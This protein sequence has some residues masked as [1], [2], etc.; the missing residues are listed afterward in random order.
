MSRRG[1]VVLGAAFAVLHVGLYALGRWP[2]QRRLWGDESMYWEA[3]G[4]ALESG[5]SGLEPLWPPLYAWFLAGCRAL[6][7]ARWPVELAQTLLLLA[8][9]LLLRDLG[10]RLELPAGAADLAA[11]IFLLYPTLAAFGHF[12]WPEVLHLLWLVAAA[13]ILAARR[14]RLG[15]CAALG[16]VLGLALLTKSLLG[17]FLP[18]LLAPLL[19]APDGS[20]AAAAG[21]GPAAT[22]PP[23]AVARHARL[24]RLG[25]VLLALTA[26]VAPTM[27]LNWRWHGRPMIANSARFNAWVGL[28]DRA[29]GQLADEIVAEEYIAWRRSAPDFAGREAILAAKIRA[30][31]S[32]RGWAELLRAQLGR[33]YFRLL[34]RESFFTDQLPGGAVHD[35]GGGYRRPPRRVAA[36]ARAAHYASYAALLLAAPFGLAAAWRQ[37]RRWSWLAGA[38]LAYHGAVFLVLHVKTRY[39]LQLLPLVA[40]LGASAA[41]AWGRW[42]VGRA[43]GEALH[44]PLGQGGVAGAAAGGGLLLWLAFGGP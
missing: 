25:V 6:A 22:F 19:I 39:R 1:W 35:V 44:A 16:V 9:A 29:G 24:A 8:S 4:R 17:P 23:A 28:N 7:D 13:W 14:D 3:G 32:E 30:L 41:L 36:L 34:D 11:A 26:T 42:A 38:F 37:R 33:Q 2:E 5:A 10:R 43:R 12:F 27:A 31:V 18:V 21:T 40:L 15:W 20:P